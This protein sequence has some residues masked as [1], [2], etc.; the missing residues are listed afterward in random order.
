MARPLEIDKNLTPLDR[1]FSITHFA[2]QMHASG[3]KEYSSRLSEGKYWLRHG[4]RME[5]VLDRVFKEYPEC[6]PSYVDRQNAQIGAMVHDEAGKGSDA[7]PKRWRLGALGAEERKVHVPAGIEFLRMYAQVFDYEI[8]TEVTRII[9][10]HHE[11]IAGEGYTG[12]KDLSFLGEWMGIIDSLVSMC[13][14]RGYNHG[15]HEI[16]S[17]I[18]AWDELNKDR[19]TKYSGDKLDKLYRIYASHPEANILG[20]GWLKM[21][22]KS[23]EEMQRDNFRAGP[24]RTIYVFNNIHHAAKTIHRTSSYAEIRE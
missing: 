5:K 6:V 21:Q 13:E 19:D 7:N 2:A 16:H 12:L 22:P 17:F 23:L 20:L 15:K 9:N 3:P 4:L 1:A 24:F 10:E 11:N 14:E 8:P 18:S